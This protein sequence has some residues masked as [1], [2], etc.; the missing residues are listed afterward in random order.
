MEEFSCGRGGSGSGIVTVATWVAAVV[1]VWS[2][3]QELP[4]A[5]AVA[6]HKKFLKKKKCD[7]IICPDW[8]N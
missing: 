7:G 8:E 1:W 3:A 5:V 6:K 4:R 2:L